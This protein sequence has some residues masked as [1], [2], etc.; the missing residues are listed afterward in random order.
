[1]NPLRPFVRFNAVGLAGA[2]VQLAAMT[3]LVHG[4][5][6]DYRLATATALAITLL[7][8]F[9]WHLHWTWRD[10]GLSGQAALRGFVMFVWGNGMVS[11]LG[12]SLLMP[13]LVDRAGLLP[14]IA[15]AVSICVCG[16][17]NF[18]LASRAFTGNSRI[19]ALRQNRPLAGLVW[20]PADH[21][22]SRTTPG[23]GRPG[24]SPA[25]SS[26]SCP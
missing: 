2:G 9:L 24:S 11:I 3:L 16:P 17:V 7:H 18:W 19:E 1:V 21:P 23:P 20:H 25:P 12:A 4:L 13:L 15:T 22:S 26:V 14:V 8:N 6:L 10:R 5:K